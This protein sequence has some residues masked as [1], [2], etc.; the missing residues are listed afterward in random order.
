M[1]IVFEKVIYGNQIIGDL[2]DQIEEESIDRWPNKYMSGVDRA[3]IDRD[4][5][6]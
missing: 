1:I 5:S 6:G 3:Q 2:T 4:V